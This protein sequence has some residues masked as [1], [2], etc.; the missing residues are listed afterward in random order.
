MLENGNGD[1][2][3]T[4]IS[5]GIGLLELV[6]LAYERSSSLSASEAELRVIDANTLSVQWPGSTSLV[7]IRLT[8]RAVYPESI[9]IF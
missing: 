4:E 1:I 2:E 6:D 7:E 3:A 8:P 5:S 9:R